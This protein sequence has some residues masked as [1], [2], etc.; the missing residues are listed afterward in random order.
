MA[1]TNKRIVYSG[2]ITIYEADVC[3]QCKEA[4]PL[5]ALDAAYTVKFTL[6]DGKGIPVFR[7]CAACKKLYRSCCRPSMYNYTT[8][9]ASAA[10]R[11]VPGE[12]SRLYFFAASSRKKVL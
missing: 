11:R 1:T 2:G 6:P 5:T 12:Q 8:P 4:I 7:L 3:N 10:C 9:P